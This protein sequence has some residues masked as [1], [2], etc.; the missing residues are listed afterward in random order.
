[1][2]TVLVR[3]AVVILA[4]AGAVSAAQSSEEFA[5]RQYE[6]GLSFLQN[7]RYSEAL[8]DFQA[9][10]DSFPQSAVA[11]EALLQVALH[12]L[13]IAHDLPAAQLAADK[14]LK[15]Y[16]NSDSAPMAYIVAGRLA[17]ARGRAA[18]DV[19]A[20]LASFERV[21]RLFPGSEAVA[22]ARFYAGDTLRLA[23][24]TDE[25]LERFRRVALEHPRS[26][27]AARAD[28]AMVP[29]LVSA[30]RAPQ[31]FARLQQIRQQFP[32]SAEAQTALRYNTILYRLYVRGRGQPPYT[33]SGR[34]VGSEA[35]RFRD[36]TGVA[37]DDGGR[38]LLGHKQGVAIFDEKGTLTRSVAAA[39]SSAFFLEERTRVVVVRGGS[40]IPDGGTAT[41]INVPIAN[42]LPRPVEEIRSVITLS[43]G[44]R[45]IGDREGRS[46]IRV[47]PQGKYIGVFASVNAE[48]LARNDLDDV[49]IIDRDSKA[50]VL[51]DRD[52]KPL[53]KIAPKGANYQLDNPVDL[54]F[55]PL[56]HLYVL[57]GNRAA[58]HVFGAK[59][60]ALAVA[61]ASGKDA[62][63][64]QRPQA[65]A[66]DAFGRLHVYDEGSQRIQVYQ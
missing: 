18:A 46:V 56:G 25:A 33:F 43:N 30:G 45:L 32:G 27:W 12:R 9:I 14:L 21:P 34:Y 10:V 35:S 58:I 65:F 11:D 31:A 22:A 52:G 53:G 47:S 2:Q 1:M 49:A 28:L 63:S 61:T 23:R 42:R 40:L 39:D 57:D 38:V 6:S 17:I 7:G 8:K 59:N 15:D 37:I 50:I 19:D 51:T 26:P 60:R 55:D 20:A 3:V 29:S 54:A 66:L 62:G 64:L 24:R 41:I 5:R 36:I 48:R 44:D 4:A 16:P 13:D